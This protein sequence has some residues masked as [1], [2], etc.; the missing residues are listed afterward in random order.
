MKQNIDSNANSKN[1]SQNSELKETNDCYQSNI[2][3]LANKKILESSNYFECSEKTSLD[4]K[5]DFAS[6][7]KAKNKKILESKFLKCTQSLSPTQSGRDSKN[8]SIST[9]NSQDK[10]QRL[11]G[12][13]GIS[14]TILTPHKTITEQLQKAIEGGL[15]IFQYRD[16]HSKD[17][18]ISGL[19]LELQE[20]CDSNN[21]LF[22]L[23]DRYELAIR[24]GVS[25]LHLGRDEVIRLEE[26]RR[27]FKG[28]IG[29]SCYDS[30]ELATTFQ[31][32]GA[33][34]VAFG[35]VFASKTKTN[36]IPCPLNVLEQAKKHIKIPICSIGGICVSNVDKLS[37][38]D[39]IAVISSLWT[40]SKTNMKDFD[41][42]RDNAKNLI[43]SW[44]YN[45]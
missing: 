32:M 20:I 18:E 31:N 7:S 21:V 3:S 2:N 8:L 10:S 35:A 27:E 44:K 30:I 45:N 24:L 17:S 41:F 15:S 22:V 39:M 26:I 40:P 5:R 28:I 6:F 16:K 33:N 13:Y 29:I 4:S 42:I 19:V 12:L 36:A 37:N 1:E 38:C 14:D 9:K 11:K 43:E 25:G 23:N 34:Y